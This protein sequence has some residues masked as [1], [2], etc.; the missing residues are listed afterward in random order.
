MTQI[1]KAYQVIKH[2]Y[3]TEKAMVLQGLEN[4]ESNPS[5][6]KCKS[7]KAVFVVD[8]HANKYEI[9]QAIEEIYRD[10]GI[11]VVGVNTI[12]VGP[13]AT[14]MR[15]RTGFR[16]GFKKAIVT[17]RPGDKLDNI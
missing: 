10:K 8:P 2:Q 5:L 6:K 13:K 16:S 3:V 15:G 1:K 9:A 11:K 17:F 12:T 7:P 4:A 14:R